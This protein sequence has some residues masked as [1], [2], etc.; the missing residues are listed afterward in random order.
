MRINL[1]LLER[2]TINILSAMHYVFANERE[3]NILLTYSQKSCLK[4]KTET[5][6]Q[7]NHDW[8]QVVFDSSNIVH[9]FRPDI[10]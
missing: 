4:K 10:V 9:T 7:T 1:L 3:N 5:Q 6:I 8:T 2:K